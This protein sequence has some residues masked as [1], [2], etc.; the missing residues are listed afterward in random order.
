MRLGL[1][2]LI[3]LTVVLAMT[4]RDTARR[5]QI[6]TTSENTAVGDAEFFVLPAASVKLPLVAAELNGR[7]LYLGNPSLIELRDSHL[8]RIGRDAQRALSIYQ[9]GE[10]GME[11]ERER[12]GKSANTYLLRVKPGEYVKVQAAAP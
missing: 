3:G 12:V 2:L 7:P 6:E 8:V 11:K 10:Y 5:S 4:F 1:A 9:L